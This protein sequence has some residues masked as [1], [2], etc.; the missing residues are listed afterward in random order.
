MVGIFIDDDV[1]TVP[2]PVIAESDV[3]CTN[4]EVEPAEP[5]TIG[6]ASTEMPNVTAAETA[7]EVAM[8]PGM[9]E[10]HTGIITAGV[11]ADPLAVGVD[12]RRVGMSCLV[13]EVRG[14]GGRSS[15]RSW[16]VGGDVLGA[17]ADLMTLSK[18][19]DR[20]QETECEQ[21]DEFFHVFSFFLST[22]GDC[23]VGWCVGAIGSA[24]VSDQ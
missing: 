14:C 3:E 9:I 10:M 12:V 13:V 17:T 1:V 21:C 6:A 7:G 15:R 4:A 18:G 5:E 11:V 22:P 19:Y 2:K 8:L 16:T 23:S 24:V 20:K